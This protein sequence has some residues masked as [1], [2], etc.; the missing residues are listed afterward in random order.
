MHRD[1][2]RFL[3]KISVN[4]KKPCLVP[5]EIF[6]CILSYSIA[7]PSR[8]LTIVIREASIKMSKSSS[9]IRDAQV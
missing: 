7:V 2:Y 1:S 4:V 6:L 5:N 8:N 3:A 9:S